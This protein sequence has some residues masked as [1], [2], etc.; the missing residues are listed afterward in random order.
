MKKGPFF[1]HSLF[2]PTHPTLLCKCRVIIIDLLNHQRVVVEL[3][4]P[5]CQLLR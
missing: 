5:F 4:T 2:R 3:P 1:T